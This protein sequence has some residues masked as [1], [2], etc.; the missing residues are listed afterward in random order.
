[1]P[2]ARLNI[3]IID[4][5]DSFVFNLSRYLEELGA[6]TTHYENTIRPTALADFDALLISPGPG[7]PEQAGRSI[8]IVQWAS[9]IN[10]PLLGVCLGHQVIARAFDC[11]VSGALRLVHGYTSI[12]EH[13]GQGIFA[14]LP[15]PF[16]GTRYH[17]LAVCELTPPLFVTARSEDGTIMGLQHE[18]LPIHGV[19][20]H[21]ESI[22][23]EYGHQLL[24]NWLDLI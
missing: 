11:E 17:S 21:P 2:G 8:E 5:R 15:S 19:Q 14:G 22:L 23:T 3:A 10:K 1:M 7:T 12:I 9:E 6:S 13:Q 24:K 4:N 16:N 18:S 20:F